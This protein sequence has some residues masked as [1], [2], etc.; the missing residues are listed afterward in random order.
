MSNEKKSK[1]T[2]SGFFAIKLTEE[3]LNFQVANYYLLPLTASM[4]GKASIV[5]CLLYIFG[6]LS[7][8]GQQQSI[9]QTAGYLILIIGFIISTII[10]KFPKNGI[11]LAFTLY[12]LSAL[13]ILI[14]NPTKI[15]GV[16]IASY[17]VIYFL[18]P[19]YQV[20]KHRDK[21]HSQHQ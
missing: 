13:L 7:F 16:L 18:Y 11:K 20:E 17:I 1:R 14:D 12:A 19:A 4:R 6:W 9:S 2:R 10:F 21:S 8:V 15:I 3:G 5:F